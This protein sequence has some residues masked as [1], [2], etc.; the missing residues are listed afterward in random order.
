LILG[1]E[2]AVL[3]AS[4][5]DGLSFDPFIQLYDGWRA[6]AADI[7]RGQVVRL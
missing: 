3:Q 4:M 5:L 2:L 7:S 6:A 1:G